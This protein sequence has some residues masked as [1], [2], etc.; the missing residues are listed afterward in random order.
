LDDFQQIINE[1]PILLEK[2]N[3]QPRCTKGEIGLG[4]VSCPK[5]GIYVL[6]EKNKAIYVGR[7]NNV[8][9]R[10]TDHCSLSS[11]HFSATFAFRLAIKEYKNKYG[12]IKKGTRKDLVK[13]SHFARLFIESKNRVSKMGIKTVEINNPITQTIFEV[14]AVMNFGTHEFNSFENH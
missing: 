14:Y 8:K 10:L 3:R 5:K 2:L 12:E 6:F 7:S 9:R 4:R 11:T 1:M 13:N